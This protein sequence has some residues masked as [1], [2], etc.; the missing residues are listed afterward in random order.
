MS[1][2]WRALIPAVVVVA[3]GILWFEAIGARSGAWNTTDPTEN[4]ASEVRYVVYGA[5]GVVTVVALMLFATWVD[6][7]NRER[8]LRW[9]GV[10]LLWLACAGICGTA[11]LLTVAV[12]IRMRDGATLMAALSILSVAGGLVQIA[13]SRRESG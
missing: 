5:G 12:G 7:V 10:L 11:I 1:R 3:L 8:K 6:I 4:V 9:Y 2:I 13:L